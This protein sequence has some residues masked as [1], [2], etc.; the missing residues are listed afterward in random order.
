MNGGYWVKKLLRSHAGK[1]A[2]PIII[3]ILVIAGVGAA[4][5][6]GGL[7]YTTEISRI[8]AD[9]TGWEGKDV[10]IK[11]E[12][13]GT[14]DFFGIHGFVVDDGT[15]EIYVDWDGVLPLVGDKVIVRG[16]VVKILSTAY[17]EATSVRNAWF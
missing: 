2:I 5:W 17:I 4:I 9:P 12:V 6:G 16:T 1:A 13:T 10:Y 3:L 11:G 8:Q 7:F 15:D 14:I